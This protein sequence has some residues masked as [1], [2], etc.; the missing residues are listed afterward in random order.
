M[1]K[2]AF[3]FVAMMAMVSTVSAQK[4]T[5]DGSWAALK[6][7]GTYALEVDYSALQVEDKETGEFKSVEEFL[8][9]RDEK[10]CNAWNTEIVPGSAAYALLVPNY[11]NKKFTYDQVAPEYKFVLKVDRLKLGFAG[12]AFIPFAGAKAGGGNIS[13]EMKMYDAKS[14]ELLGSAVFEDVQGV[15]HVTDAVRWGMSYYELGKRL[16]KAVKKAK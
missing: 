15:S 6:G 8:K 4:I 13:G 9:T 14:G 3:W 16:M 10:F 2:I 7:A 5:L 11:A 1:K 12:G